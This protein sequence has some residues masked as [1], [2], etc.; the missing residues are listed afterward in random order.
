MAK[1]KI[2]AKKKK[3]I[4]MMQLV[5]SRYLDRIENIEICADTLFPVTK[6]EELKKIKRLR[7]EIS[8]LVSFVEA[9]KK[10]KI[11]IENERKFISSIR[12]LMKLEAVSQPEILINSLFLCLFSTFDAYIGDLLRCLYQNRKELINSIDASF[13]TKDILKWRSIEQSRRIIIEKD[14]DK[15]IRESYDDRF[16]ILE[17]KFGIS[18]RKFQNWASF[19]ECCQRRNIHAHCDGIVTEQYITICKKE[20][21]QFKSNI[22]VGD[23]LIVHSSYFYNSIFLLNEVGFKLGQVL[24]RKI[25]PE[26]LAVADNHIIGYIYDLL[27]AEKWELAKIIGEFGL[28]LPKISSDAK[29][30]KLQIN[31]SQAFKWSG[32]NSRAKKIIDELD[33]SSCVDD[34]KLAVSVIKDDFKKAKDFMITIGEK[35]KLIQK[36]DY[37]DWPLFREFRKSREFLAA[38]KKIYKKDFGDEIKKQIKRE[39]EKGKKQEKIEK[40]RS[41]IP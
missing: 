37:H 7:K 41:Q 21:Y 31:Y 10:K 25:L 39:S 29:R 26:E 28:H 11:I 3:E 8:E 38:Y 12:K 24:W 2:N 5:I 30:R 23:E 18:L 19:V 22:K 9:E 32:N 17:N 33:W 15:L 27:E 20:G 36:Q 40:G 16:R 13:S 1:I 14:L 6:R 35:G 34:F 4:L